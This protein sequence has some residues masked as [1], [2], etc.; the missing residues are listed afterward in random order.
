MGRG[1]N[2]VEKS[3]DVNTLKKSKDGLAREV[4]KG[5]VLGVGQ[6]VHQG[7]GRQDLLR[8]HRLCGQV[9]TRGSFRGRF[10]VSTARGCSLGTKHCLCTK[11]GR[12]SE[13]GAWDKRFALLGLRC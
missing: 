11:P 10:Q 7:G 5:R 12:S 2:T 13:R 6:R 9:W 4:R 3:S 1:D 8:L